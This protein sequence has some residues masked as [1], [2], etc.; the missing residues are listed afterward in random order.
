MKKYSI[1]I[2]ILMQNVLGFAQDAVALIDKANSDYQAKSYTTSEENY[3]LAVAKAD[4]ILAGKYDL[5]NAIYKQKR[6]NEAG[7]LY[8]NAITMAKTKMQKAQVYH[9]LGNSYF[10]KGKLEEAIEAYKNALRNNPK[11]EETRYNLALAK[12]LLKK[13]NKNKKNDKKNDKNKDKKDKDKD[14]KD[15]KNK[16]KKDKGKDKK[17]DKNKDKKDKGKDKKDDKNKDKKDKGK[18]KKDD[19]KKDKKDKGKDKKN[20]KN[21]DK[22]DKDKDKKDDKNKDD[23]GDK[24]QNPNGAPQ[25]VGL[26]PQ[27]AKR[28]LQA[29]QNQ[30]NKTQK[31]VKAQ[32]VQGIPVKTEKDW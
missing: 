17:D 26:S 4:T 7:E 28:L 31:K 19:K 12:E 25:K 30:E 9:N 5:A 23:K 11:D 24:N 3:R 16:D 13:K 2:I 14:K 20:D 18:D 32:Q 10:Q 29:V 27:E 6:I 21:K 1:L 8:L 15:D 22:K